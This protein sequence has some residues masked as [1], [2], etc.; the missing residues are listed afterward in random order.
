MIVQNR[1]QRRHRLYSLHRK[2]RQRQQGATQICV[3]LGNALA[4]LPI[5]GIA[6]DIP[7]AMIAHCGQ[8][9]V[10]HT[11]PWRCPTCAQVVLE[12]TDAPCD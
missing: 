1:E 11:L 12:S 9:H 5:G 10:V 6:P 4:Q 3:A 7:E 2:Y 8:W